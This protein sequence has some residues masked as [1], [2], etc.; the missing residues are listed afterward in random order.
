MIV[1]SVFS[2]QDAIEAL[3]QQERQHPLIER[4][5]ELM[6]FLNE[7][8]R[9]KSLKQ[10]ASSHGQLIVIKGDAGIG[11]TRMLDAIIVAASKSDC[12]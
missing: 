9:F 7:L 1:S 5:N 8:E 3:T 10:S 4:K 2:G 6:Q 11:K 12:K